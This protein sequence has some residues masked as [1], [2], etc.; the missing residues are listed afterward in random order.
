VIVERDGVEVGSRK[1]Y[2]IDE[3]DAEWEAYPSFMRDGRLDLFDQ[4]IRFRV[5]RNGD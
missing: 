4:G 3:V 5:V 1:V 2:A